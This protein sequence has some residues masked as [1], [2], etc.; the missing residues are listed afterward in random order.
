[1][2]TSEHYSMFP[3][4]PD[5]MGLW[6][7]R[8]ELPERRLR[9]DILNL[10]TRFVL[11]MKDEKKP[12]SGY[13]EGDNSL[14][15]V[16]AIVLGRDPSRRV[17]TPSAEVCDTLADQFAAEHNL[18]RKSQSIGDGFRCIMGRER[19][20]SAPPSISQIRRSIPA[21][22]GLTVKGNAHLFSS[23]YGEGTWDAPAAI[24]QGPLSAL[25]AL[26]HTAHTFGQQRY[27]VETHE[28][29]MVFF[30]NAPIE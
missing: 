4:Q 27:V 9:S 11:T 3:V 19:G 25:K 2:T 16:S 21:N 14:E 5:A 28:R 29:T 24:I 8:L 7:T 13:F 26:D 6:T 15:D 20:Y 10:I 22:S 30:H 1:M 18:E 23:R 12:L 17:G